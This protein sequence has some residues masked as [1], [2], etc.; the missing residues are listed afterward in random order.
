MAI[1]FRNHS[2][3]SDI[4]AVNPLASFVRMLYSN[5]NARDGV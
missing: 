5:S 2:T 4:G 3:Y 1:A